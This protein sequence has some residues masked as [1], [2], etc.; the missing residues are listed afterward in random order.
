MRNEI[1]DRG[2]WA[3][4]FVFRDALIRFIVKA[5]YL[6]AQAKAMQL[7][8]IIFGYLISYA[9]RVHRGDFFRLE[10]RFPRLDL[11]FK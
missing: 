3:L 5:P 10:I 2:F 4:L 6:V 11:N 7:K 1:D 9:S 8:G